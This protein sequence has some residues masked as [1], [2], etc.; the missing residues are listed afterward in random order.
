MKIKK[1]EMIQKTQLGNLKPGNVFTPIDGFGDTTDEVCMVLSDENLSNDIQ[2]RIPIVNLHKGFIYW[3][4]ES[5]EVDAR[6]Y[7]ELMY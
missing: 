2:G 6:P 1:K 5:D 7:A 4:N 3:K